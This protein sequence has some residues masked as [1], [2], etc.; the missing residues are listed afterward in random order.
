ME[1]ILRNQFGEEKEVSF[2][3]GSITSIQSNNIKS[4][5][6]NF[7]KKYSPIYINNYDLYFLGNSVYNEIELYCGSIDYEFVY[8]LLNILEIDDSFLRRKVS[9]LSYTEKIYLN[10]IRRLSTIGKIVLFDDVF[11]Y[12]DYANQ[13]RVSNL[14]HYLKDNM[15]TVII[16]SNDVNVLYKLAD[17]SVVWYKRTYLYGNSDDVYT[18]VSKFIKN[19]IAVPILPLITYKAKTE[20]NVKLFYSKDVRDIIKDIYK[21]V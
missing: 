8:E 11:R 4:I 5:L 10:I 12:I 19:R 1:L 14:L 3:E 18:S 7:L 15:Y 2:E 13:K 17:Y 9:E 6:N 16:T 20:K 21:H